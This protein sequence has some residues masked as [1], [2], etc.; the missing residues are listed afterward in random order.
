MLALYLQ[1]IQQTYPALPLDRVAVIEAGQYNRVLLLNDQVIMRF[2][3]FPAGA[4]RLPFEA[5][6]LDQLAPISPIAIPQYRY[7]Q[8]ST[9][10]QLPFAGYH[11]LSGTPLHRAQLAT[12]SAAART[13]LAVTLGR[14]LKA[15]H[16]FPYWE[17]FPAAVPLGYGFTTATWQDGWRDIY[18]RIVA[19][20]LPRITNTAQENITATFLPYID[21]PENFAFTPTI[22]HG[23]FGC[24]NI[25]VNEQ[26]EATGIIDFGSAGLGDPAADL[27]ALLTLGE[28]IVIAACTVYPALKHLLPR[29]NFYRSTFAALDAL[30]G[31]EHDDAEAF[32]S[33]VGAYDPRS[34]QRQ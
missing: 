5:K 7:R 23:D 15:L 31:A 16:S 27:A 13:A 26:H 34:T 9:I 21:N 3:R 33:G 4:T 22:I 25:L 29:A 11:K 18:Q 32:A 8:F 2:P 1:Q 6:L 14:F 20:V 12:L 10:N 17:I 30:Y 28:P 24:G 19:N